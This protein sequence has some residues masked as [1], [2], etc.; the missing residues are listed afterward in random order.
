M[1]NNGRYTH[2]LGRENRADRVQLMDDVRRER[3]PVRRSEHASYANPPGDGRVQQPY[4][5]RDDKPTLE[6]GES[7]D[8]LAAGRK[9]AATANPRGCAPPGPACQ[10]IASTVYAVSQP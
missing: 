10:G 8:R 9:A 5:H 6:G 2:A 3:C 7:S 4:Q 1:R